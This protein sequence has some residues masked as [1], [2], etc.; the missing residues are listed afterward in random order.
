MA[1][2]MRRLNGGDKQKYDYRYSKLDLV[3]GIL[4]R[5]GWLAEAEL[6][7]LGQDKMRRIKA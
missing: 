6:T 1:L 2:R 7:G 5:E 4:L 3:F